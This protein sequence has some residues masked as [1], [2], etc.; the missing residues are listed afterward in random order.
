[1]GQVFAFRALF[2]VETPLTPVLHKYRDIS[3]YGISTAALLLLLAK[4]A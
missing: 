4:S 2:D 1:M 3:V